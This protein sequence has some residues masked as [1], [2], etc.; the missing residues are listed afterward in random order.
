MTGSTQNDRGGVF[1]AKEGRYGGV[2]RQVSLPRASLTLAG[3]PMWV[4]KWRFDATRE[5][6]GKNPKS[7]REPAQSLI[8]AVAPLTDTSILEP[9]K[10]NLTVPDDQLIASAEEKLRRGKVTPEDVVR[11][12]ADPEVW[13]YRGE[14]LVVTCRDD[15]SARYGIAP[16]IDAAEVANAREACAALRR[17]IGD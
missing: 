10:L 9:A 2:E 4:T 3:Y 5:R 1:V 8:V 15:A 13:P 16:F 12:L 6:F 11:A 14:W 17:V 7:E